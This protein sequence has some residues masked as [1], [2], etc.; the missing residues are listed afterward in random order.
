MSRFVNLYAS[1]KQLRGLSCLKKGLVLLFL[2]AFVICF[3]GIVFGITSCA[4]VYASGNIVI[5]NAA[6]GIIKGG[7][8][9]TGGNPGKSCRTMWGNERS[10]SQ[11]G[12]YGPG[13]LGGVN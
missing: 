10:G 12:T 6:S 9:G 4:Y 3:I 11:G 13:S 2:I 1:K 5:S 7:D 8:G